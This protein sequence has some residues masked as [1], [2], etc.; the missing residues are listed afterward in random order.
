MDNEEIKLLNDL[1]N[2]QPIMSICW[3]GLESDTYYSDHFLIRYLR[4]FNPK[5]KRAPP[6]KACC[7]PKKYYFRYS[8]I[9]KYIKYHTYPM[10]FKI[11]SRRW[12]NYNKLLVPTRIVFLFIKN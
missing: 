3:L 9:V 12:L 8:P 4:P 6:G 7:I 11:Q 10:P 5:K 2:V 1:K